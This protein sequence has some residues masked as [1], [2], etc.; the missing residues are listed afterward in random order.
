MELKPRGRMSTMFGD[1]LMSPSDRAA[2]QAALK[3]GA[4]VIKVDAAVG[5]DL[6]GAFNCCGPANAASEAAEKVAA[7][8]GMDIDQD[9]EMGDSHIISIGDHM[10]E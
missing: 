10:S 7:I 5:S 8:Y 9:S 6:P 2:R 3:S 1:A 4:R